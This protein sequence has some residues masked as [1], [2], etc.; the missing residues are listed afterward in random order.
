[1]PCFFELGKKHLGTIFKPAEQ[2]KKTHLRLIGQTDRVGR[3]S[4][5]SMLFSN[6]C[7]ALAAAPNYAARSID[8]CSLGK[9]HI[10]GARSLSYAFATDFF[11]EKLDS[12]C[13]KLF[14]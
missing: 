14:L 5:N 8:L 11:H 12:L 2:Q 13:C 10:F 3:V 7:A 1:M 6:R 9:V 4:L